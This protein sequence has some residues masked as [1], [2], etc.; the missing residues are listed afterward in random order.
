MRDAYYNFANGS[1]TDVLLMLGDNVYETGTDVEYTTRH[2]NVYRDLLRQTVSWPTIGNHDTAGSSSP[3]STIPYYQSFSLPMSGEAGGVASGTEDYYSFDYGEIHFICLDSMTSS[4]S[5]TGPMATWLRQD[6][7]N[8]LQKWVIAYWHHPPYSK[9][10]DSDTDTIA[11]EMRSNIVPVLE[12]YGVDLVLLGHSH[13][14]ERSYLIDGHY[15]GSATFSPGTMVKDGSDGRGI[16][17]YNK[18]T[19]G[20]AGREGAVY[21]VAGS[22]GKTQDYPGI[23]DNG[24]GNGTGHPAMFLSWE[25]MGSVIVDVD[26]HRMD[27]RFLRQNGTIGDTFA[28]TRGPRTNAAPSVTLTTPVTGG[29]FS[30]NTPITLNATATDSDQGIKEVVFYANSS[31]IGVVTNA[32]SG[33]RYHMNYSPPRVG[34]YTFEARA[35]DHFGNSTFSAAVN[36]TVAAGPPT[37]DT[38]APAAVVNL[39]T[40]SI[41]TASVALNWTAP[42]D[43]QNTGTATLLRSPL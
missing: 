14:Y 30:E 39:A 34:S 10:H 20:G 9:G 23:V 33:D 4:R 40:S 38:T 18:P 11:I 42:G 12:E 5:A 36:I 43:D 41:T 31:R 17:G 3:S 16:G 1:Y 32:S 24:T 6:L 22:S 26:G 37:P 2:F 25:R 19:L 29:Q 8:T 15:G 27:V 7:A 13:A 28:I 21:V 35:V